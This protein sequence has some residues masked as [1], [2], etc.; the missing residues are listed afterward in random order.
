VVLAFLNLMCVSPDDSFAGM[1]MQKQG[2]MLAEILKHWL[3][4]APL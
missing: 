3:P 1:E 2:E 4:S